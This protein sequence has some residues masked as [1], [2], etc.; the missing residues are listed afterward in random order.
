MIAAA[1]T[2]S[3]LGPPDKVE[4]LR[5]QRDQR[6]PF[7]VRF[8]DGAASA[9]R[10]LGVDPAATDVVELPSI[11]GV[12]ATLNVGVALDLSE[13]AGVAQVWYLHPDLAPLY[14]RSIQAL[15]H[16]ART[17]PLPSVA[18]LS[19]GPEPRFW[20][21]EPFEDEPMHAATRVSAEA[22]LVP[23]VAVGNN[24]RA[25]SM[26]GWI[27]PWSWPRWVISVGAYD[28]ERQRVADFSA[29]GA[30]DRPETWPDVVAQGVDVVGTYP[31]GLAK[32][33]SRRQRDEESPLFRRTVPRAK[34]DIYTLESG[35][36][37]AA[38]TV[39]GAAA[40]I[41]HFVKE[42]MA[43]SPSTDDGRPLFA[44]TA[45]PGRRRAAAVA[46]A[47]RLCGT[48]TVAAD[49]SVTFEYRPAT[50]WKLV[51]QVLV[52]TALPLDGVDAAAAGAGL[53]DPGYVKRQFGRFG[54]IDPKFFAAK[55]LEE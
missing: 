16:S 8:T 49:G 50:P 4:A 15:N 14:V 39:S 18:N 46:N 52:D 32:S 35:T 44:L 23:V 7:I 3:T 10:V 26:P 28:G 9:A 53:V 29:R 37:Q 55:V 41:M 22:G 54:V 34:W 21:P 11:D 36:S 24:P 5:A 25:E 2:S 19:I 12:A 27:N 1:A 51:K 42:T 38:A 31:T 47:P 43:R 33:A 6:Y 45:D 30:P 20:T 13:R 17:L 48:A 40:Q